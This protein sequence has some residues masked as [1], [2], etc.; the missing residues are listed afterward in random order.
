M[1]FIRFKAL[2]Y[3]PLSG[4]TEQMGVTPIWINPDRVCS[5]ADTSC[6][7]DPDD[8]HDPSLPSPHAVIEVTSGIKHVVRGS[9]DS[10][11]EQ[12]CG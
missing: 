7:D 8:F 4:S 2:S 10:V 5:V 9:V 3:K 1:R 12:L 6:F 11:I